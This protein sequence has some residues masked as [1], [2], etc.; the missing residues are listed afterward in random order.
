MNTSKTKYFNP[1]LRR[2]N[3]IDTVPVVSTELLHIKDKVSANNVCFNFCLKICL[4][5]FKAI[6]KNCNNTSPQ[7]ENN[8]QNVSSCNQNN[9]IK[10]PVST[11]G[12]GSGGGVGT[13]VRNVNISDQQQ[14][15]SQIMILHGQGENAIVHGVAPNALKSST[16]G[17]NCRAESKQSHHQFHNK[18]A[19]IQHPPL[20]T[21]KSVTS[22]LNQ[23][24]SAPLHPINVSCAILSIKKIQ[25][26]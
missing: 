3:D 26:S 8:F 10:T 13:S 20:T 16:I 17:G 19:N 9:S 24:N 23:N 11:A 21:K 2:R 4:I 25:S 6:D 18:H 14:N 12:I 22:P 7:I 15:S 5:F 1:Q